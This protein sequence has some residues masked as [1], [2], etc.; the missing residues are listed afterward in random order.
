MYTYTLLICIIMGICALYIFLWV[1]KRFEILKPLY[2]F[3]IIIMIIYWYCCSIVCISELSLLLYKENWYEWTRENILCGSYCLIKH[4]TL[5]F[6]KNIITSKQTPQC[7]YRLKII[8]VF[9]IFIK[10]QI[11]QVRNAAYKIAGQGN[12]QLFISWCFLKRK[13][14]WFW[15]VLW[16]LM[17]SGV[18]WPHK[19][20]K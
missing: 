14:C 5:T 13:E 6:L 8:F 19:N 4:S 3:P 16:F 20:K 7:I 1:V 10:Y 2:K 18:G 11:S 9:T 15:F 12:Q 17:S